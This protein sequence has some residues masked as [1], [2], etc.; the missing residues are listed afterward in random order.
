LQPPVPIVRTAKGICPLFSQHHTAQEI[1]HTSEYPNFLHFLIPAFRELLLVRLDAGKPIDSVESKFRHV[2][3]EILNRLPNNELL[4]PYTPELL[5]VA[6][7]TLARDNEDNALTCL[8]IVFDLHKNFRP[9][10]ESEVQAFLD[11]VNKIYRA[12]PLSME[13]AFIPRFS[14]ATDLSDSDAIALRHLGSTPGVGETGKVPLEGIGSF[15]VLTECPLIVMLLFQLYPD[16]IQTNIPQLAPLMMGALALRVPQSAYK[17]QRERYMEFVACQVKTLSFLT[18]LLRGFSD[19]MRPYESAIARSVIAL[20]A[21]CPSDATPIRK[22]LLVAT[23]HILATEFRRGFFEH[24]SRIFDEDILIGEDRRCNDSLRPLAFSTLADLVYHVLPKLTCAQLSTVVIMFSRNLHDATIPVSVQTTSVRLLLNLV[25]FIFHNVSLRVFRSRLLILCIARALVSRC[26]A[27]RSVL[28]GR[29]DANWTRELFLSHQSKGPKAL[30]ALPSSAVHRLLRRYSLGIRQS[31]SRPQYFFITSRTPSSSVSSRALSDYGDLRSLLLTLLRGLKTVMW[32]ISHYRSRNKNQVHHRHRASNRAGEEAPS[33]EDVRDQNLLR[34]SPATATNAA[35][36]LLG[37]IET[38][39]S[40]DRIAFREESRTLATLFASGIECCRAYARNAQ[41][42]DSE[43]KEAFD[44]FAGAFTVLDARSLCSSIGMNVPA[45]FSAVQ[46]TPQ[47]L[48]VAQLLLANTNSSELFAK[49]LLDHLVREIGAL[50]FIRLSSSLCDRNCCNT[51]IKFHHASVALQLF[52]IVFGS[53]AL[54]DGNKE[55]LHGFVRLVVIR[56]LALAAL[57][58]EPLGFFTLLRAL[59]RALDPLSSRTT[60][61]LELSHSELEPVVPVVLRA[62]RELDFPCAA[63]HNRPV[64]TELILTLPARLLVLIDHFSEMWPAILTALHYAGDLASVA[65]RFV[66][67][68]VD[69][70]G[71]TVFFSHISL[72]VGLADA[73]VTGVCHH[74]NPLRCSNGVAA[75]RLLG[76]L[77][78][79]SRSSFPKPSTLWQSLRRTLITS[80]LSP[81]TPDAGHLQLMELALRLKFNW[82]CS[83][84]RSVC[85]SAVSSGFELDIAP[86]LSIVCSLFQTLSGMALMSTFQG[87]AA[88][89]SYRTATSDATAETSTSKDIPSAIVTRFRTLCFRLAVTT[90]GCL[91]RGNPLNIVTACVPL[92]DSSHGP[93]YRSSTHFCFRREAVQSQLCPLFDLILYAA[94]DDDISVEALPIL[95]ALCLK[96]CWLYETSTPTSLR[97]DPLYLLD[98][99]AVSYADPDQECRDV[100]KQLTLERSCGSFVRDALMN[101]LMLKP[102]RLQGVLVT[103]LISSLDSHGSLSKH[104][105]CAQLDCQVLP[106]IIVRLC[107]SVRASSRMCKAGIVDALVQITTRINGNLTVELRNKILGACLSALDSACTCKSMQSQNMIVSSICRLLR[108][109]LQVY[110]VGSLPPPT[111]RMLTKALC[112]VDPATRIAAQCAL[113]EVS[114]FH[115]SE[116]ASVFSHLSA[117]TVVDILAEATRSWDNTSTVMSALDAA[118]YL[119]ALDPPA[120]QLNRCLMTS[121]VRII[122]VASIEDILGENG[123]VASSHSS[124]V[125]SR[126][127]GCADVSSPEICVLLHASGAEEYSVA[128]RL[129]INIL[130][131]AFRMLIVGIRAC[132]PASLESIFTCT[133]REQF[134]S[135]ALDAMRLGDLGLMRMADCL[136]KVVLT[137]QHGTHN[138]GLFERKRTILLDVLCSDGPCRYSQSASAFFVLKH[139]HSM[140]MLAKKNA[141]DTRIRLLTHLEHLCAEAAPEKLMAVAPLILGL[142][143]ILPGTSEFSRDAAH[144]KS[145]MILVADAGASVMCDPHTVMRRLT[146]AILE[147]DLRHCAKHVSSTSGSALLCLGVSL[148]HTQ[149]C[150]GSCAPR[151]SRTGRCACALPGGYLVAPLAD[152]AARHPG[153]AIRHFFHRETLLESN[154]VDLL[155]SILTLSEASNLRSQLVDGETINILLTHVFKR[156]NS[157]KHLQASFD[158]HGSDTRALSSPGTQSSSQPSQNQ[159]TVRGWNHVPVSRWSSSHGLLCE[160]EQG[161]LTFLRKFHF[162]RIVRTLVDL[163]SGVIVRNPSLIRA[164]RALWREWSNLDALGRVDKFWDDIDSGTWRSFASGGFVLVDPTTRYEGIQL[165]AQCVLTYGKQ[166]ASDTVIVYE[167]LAAL[168]LPSALDFA[169]VELFLCETV[170]CFWGTLDRDSVFICFVRIFVDRRVTSEAKVHALRFIV[171]PMVIASSIVHGLKVRYKLLCTLMWC[172]LDC[173]PSWFSGSVELRVE[174]LKLMTVLIEFHGEDIIEQRKEFIKF[175]WSHLKSEDSL[176]R[177][178]AYVNVCRFISTFD[179]PPKIVLQVRYLVDCAQTT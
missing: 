48:G 156:D 172:T 132:S 87:C 69:T 148:G 166:V 165:V 26:S 94:I 118:T 111:A 41:A 24:I 136:V 17:T 54:F 158:C 125:H 31:D 62:L 88:L 155:C 133:A 112:N 35:N 86:T 23:R 121:L 141:S 103:M 68:C 38:H 4:R 109:S 114:L 44:S 105:Q 95:Q 65:L 134:L 128:P 33:H 8:R 78:G 91:V 71:L 175:A 173:E 18:Y 119:M 85:N 161:N 176:A 168:M 12:L 9:S 159:S 164:C 153:A 146:R 124:H 90:V 83:E 25:E 137:C 106:D 6:S 36:T 70:I 160:Q 100:D 21:A 27:L 171:T 157:G 154:Q 2:I 130:M 11:L 174:L 96:V 97:S 15:K 7:K 140:P 81:T 122:T 99:D 142:M 110:S 120:L 139:L 123:V 72:H 30:E 92:R 42:I 89:P 43:L 104:S 79:F 151:D 40:I 16:Y 147:I 56:S 84:K 19:L 75:L 61:K 39:D 144:L 169:D 50:S 76:K 115:H 1:V 93:H 163:D 66:E 28:G 127:A 13:K 74:I 52:K 152:F 138:L 29:T 49:L 126:L 5:R 131:S 178:W 143:A 34:P 113:T 58:H 47:I 63:P 32:C 60:R 55:A 14:A 53:V 116:Q 51:P 82:K 57:A 150:F 67:R 10:L 177:Q 37:N 77:G 73:L 107:T 170:P 149:G 129:L 145:K 64:V 22:E 117:R 45:L 135:V 59:F 3:L 80:E 179:T 102:Q 108:L 162:M 46:D 20:M 167:F 98:T 101:A